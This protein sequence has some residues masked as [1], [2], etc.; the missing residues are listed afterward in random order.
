[1]I[2]GQRYSSLI[3]AKI[4]KMQA[5]N[6]WGSHVDLLLIEDIQYKSLAT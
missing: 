2:N 1:M 3:I 6:G 4:G 5:K